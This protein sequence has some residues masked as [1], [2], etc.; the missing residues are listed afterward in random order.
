MT[1]DRYS[2]NITQQGNGAPCWS[3]D[4]IEHRRLWEAAA[5]AKTHANIKTL[6]AAP[7]FFSIWSSSR[8]LS[9]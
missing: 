6:H 9:F 3:V 5:A 2:V 7:E 4:R 1:S 8:M